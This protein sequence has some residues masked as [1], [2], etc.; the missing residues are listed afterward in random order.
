MPSQLHQIRRGWGPTISGTL[1]STAMP[2]GT[3]LGWSTINANGENQFALANGAVNSS[4]GYGTPSIATLVI[5]LGYQ[6]RDS[7]SFTGLNPV[8]MLFGFGLETP[9][10]AAGGE[11]SV[12]PGHDLDVEGP[13]YILESNTTTYPDGTLVSSD[14][15]A[16]TYTIATSTPKGTELT[17]RN[18]LLAIAAAGD[19]V[20]HIL[21]GQKTPTVSGNVRIAVLSTHGYVKTSNAI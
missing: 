15:N 10:L 9:F 6:T 8:E 14:T 21:V 7:R 4:T 16:A 20:A 3:P 19:Y 11:G 18:G 17:F 13:L 12:E 1:P 5:A 2:I